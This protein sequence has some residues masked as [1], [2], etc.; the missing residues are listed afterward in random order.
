[1]RFHPSARELTCKVVY[2]GP[3]LAGK[4][5]NLQ[6]IHDR[7]PAGSASDLVTVDTHSE[8]T[9]HFDW[10]A[11]ELGEIQGYSVKVE[12][13]TVPGQSYYAATRRQ[14][15]G[16]ADGVVFVADSRREAL[17][18]NIDAM[19]EMLGN[20]RHHG[21][22]S[23]LP[24]VMQYNKQDLASALKR[25]SLE[26]LM[27]VRSWPSFAAVA[28]RGD[29]V[30]ET[31]RRLLQLIAERAAQE[32]VPPP[33]PKVQTPK[34]SA[35]Q[36]WLISCHRCQTI[37]EVPSAPVG[38]IY[39]CGVC[40]SALEVVDSD[41][42]L[43]RPPAKRS[44]DSSGFAQIAGP[45]GPQSP[46]I[47]PGQGP[48]SQPFANPNAPGAGNATGMVE[49]AGYE[50]VA[51][52][53]ESPQG[54]RMRLRESASGRLH[55]CLAVAPN[56]MRYPNYRDGFDGFVRMAGPLRHPNILPLG[57]MRWQNESALLLSPEP[58]DHEPLA[59]VLARRRAL[60]PPHAMGVLRQLA[61]ALEE[62]AR[63]GVIHGWLRPDVI[64]VN[65]DGAVLLDEL[66]LPK[67]QAFLVRELSGGSGAT[68]YYLAPENIED[69]QPDLRSDIFVLGALL[70][71]MVT[72]EGLV[73]GATAQAA[74]H[75]VITNG[76]RPLR[77][78]QPGVSRNLDI[79]YQR[80]VAIDR[81]DRFQ[82]Y[83]EL[84][85]QIDQF[86]GGA[87]RQNL[88]LT[89][90][91]PTVSSAPPQR[92]VRG[93]GSSAI[94]NPRAPGASGGSGSSAIRNPRAP[95]TGG[96]GS[97]AHRN[98]RASTGGTGGIRRNA[99]GGSGAIARN[100]NAGGE[101]LPPIPQP[102]PQNN[103]GLIVVVVVMFVLLIAAGL[104][105]IATNIHSDDSTPP[106][107]DN[108]PTPP[109]HVTPVAPAPTTT[110]ARTGIGTGTASAS[111]DS[112]IPVNRLEQLKRIA[113]LRVQDHYAAAD[114]IVQHMINADDRTNLHAAILADHD[115]SRTAVEN[116][117][118]L[119]PDL[120]AVRKM[121]EPARTTWGMPGDADWAAAQL[122]SASE[123]LAGAPPPADAP[124]TPPTAP[125]T[126]PV[127]GSGA[128]SPI[129]GQPLAV[130]PGT[131]TPVDPATTPVANP[132]LPPL[133]PV[134]LD[135]VAP[136]SQQVDQALSADQ[137]DKATAAIA[138]LDGDTYAAEIRALKRKVDLWGK[139]N[140][141]LNR[142][143]QA[144]NVHLRM[145]HPTTDE[146]CDVSQANAAGID[147]TSPAGSNTTLPWS[148]VPAAAAAKLL[149]DAAGV[150]DANGEERGISVVAYLIAAD[151]ANAADSSA[152][153]ANAGAQMR[154][155]RA[156]FAA[157]L[158]TDLDTC[159]T[160]VKRLDLLPL[161]ARG[162]DAI[163]KNDLRALND[164]I[165]EFHK[166]DPAVQT[167]LKP[168]I[169]GFTYAAGQLAARTAAPIASTLSGPAPGAKD[170]VD[171]T[172]IE[173]V[174]SFPDR[175]DNA[176]VV[177]GGALTNKVDGH[178]GR[179]DLAG[180]HAVSV[181]FQI[182]VAQGTFGIDFRGAKTVL[183][184]AASTYTTV[185]RSTAKAKSFLLLPK[186]E[187]TLL[188]ERKDDTHTEISFNN[189]AETAEIAIVDT[190]DVLNLEVSGGGIIAIDEVEILR[191]GP[192]AGAAID[193]KAAVRVLGWEPLGGAYFEAPSIILPPSA[194]TSSGIATALKDNIS[195][196]ILELKGQ[197]GL[198]VA[199]VRTDDNKAP[200]GWEIPFPDRANQTMEVTIR[201]ND[202][203]VQVLV[204]GKPI[205][206]AGGGTLPD[207]ADHLMITATNQATV[208]TTPK[209]E[210]R[211]P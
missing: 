49:I 106:V 98:P 96:S 1:M 148:Q 200:S 122:A 91:I 167:A 83:G 162:N 84:L 125:P 17:D 121:L 45:N 118:A 134:T 123:R 15:L 172:T 132:A 2:Y 140:A 65:G 156:L 47:S 176:W 82:T 105:Y 69:T 25:E 21:L 177:N 29:G 54:R 41:R 147:L 183:D 68:E 70:F 114:D 34:P 110:G 209:P 20:L 198:R 58:A 157:D 180:A 101:P 60:A 145:R 120:D 78:A 71:R 146:S 81:K 161:G 181:R 56:L 139:R 87:Q 159:L 190:S 5:T 39:T 73:T 113:D 193:R 170:K 108:T 4:S 129:T 187:Y 95:A 36:T 185:G 72:G 188:C 151:A 88:R 169:D 174:Q 66:A 74:L 155:S 104:Y 46:Q 53:D 40:A 18:E 9:L 182:L 142:A 165:A 76:A 86:G 137:P 77:A 75:K 16:G 44:D 12:F 171:F 52:L 199:F 107:V 19:N 6:F 138:T 205:D 203:T 175:D 90:P 197:G 179:G 30:L 94:R 153:L 202:K 61:L 32:T 92:S 133:P 57:T 173:D 208:L 124:S 115:R 13:W 206:L 168:E 89:G 37:L 10:M 99:S 111:V 28:T 7:M 135:A 109:P 143:I 149:G 79:F 43:T 35:P 59:H 160:L 93:S 63:H 14:V 164:V 201:W 26:P 189:G 196:Y 100:R 103:N 64:L 163:K 8:R 191:D 62:A 23:D 33:D 11:V 119:S 130:G 211:T 112:D 22:P 116:A 195:G 48:F 136:V 97:S 131:V 184:L 166:A 207:K 210:Y 42:G 152:D 3:G 204:D 117:V 178:L 80:L 85:D 144:G 38:A 27:N 194:G 126:T 141:L 67:R 102:R 150:A 51:N 31:M 24:L 55:R 128:V 186:V 127:R 192:K 154:K 50:V 158:A